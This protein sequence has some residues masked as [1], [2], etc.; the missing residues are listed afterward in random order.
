LK[1]DGNYK[2]EAN[3]P[4]GVIPITLILAANGSQLSGSCLTPY[5]NKDF[6]GTI[7]AG[8]EIRFSAE[9]KSPLGKIQLDVE[10]KIEGTEIRGQVKTG[11]FGNAPFK[12]QKVTGG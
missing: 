10:A 11:R 5:G 12:G 3:S 8:D 4:L 2:C 1:I 9:V 6:N 7:S